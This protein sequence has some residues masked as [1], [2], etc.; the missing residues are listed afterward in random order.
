MAET[1]NPQVKHIVP[2]TGYFEIS[3]YDAEGK[4]SKYK[5]LERL[6]S[7]MTQDKL[8]EFYES[9]K[10]KGNPLPLNSIQVMEILEDTANSKDS[11]LKNYI[12][13]SLRGNW[14]NTLSR[15]IYKPVE[16]KDVTIHNCGTSDEYSIT[17]DIVG[18][19]GWIKDINNSNALE[20]ILKTKDIK[21]LNEIS[22][23]INST[24]MYFWR[25]NSKPS[26][27]TERV[28]RFVAYD[29]GLGLYADGVLFVEYPAFLVE[30]I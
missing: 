24:P 19:D 10:Q 25:I 29:V 26:K 22:N 16:E 14:I 30:Q 1:I 23:T 17:G 5:L 12:H 9:E 27:K 28:V 6:S 13:K 20:S 18:K 7:S 2:S 11:E 15:V 4:A 3:K 8:A 21:K